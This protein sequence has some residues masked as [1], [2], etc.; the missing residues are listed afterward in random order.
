VIS[1]YSCEKSSD[2][3]KTPK[4]PGNPN[5]TFYKKILD[6]YFVTSIAFDSKGN[7]WIGTGDG[8]FINN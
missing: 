5:T 7:A 3:G 8:I 4:I 2:Y 1:F 6:G